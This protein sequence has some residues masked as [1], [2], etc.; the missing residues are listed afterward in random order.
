MLAISKP[1]NGRN[2][3]SSSLG[4]R[5]I[6]FTSILVTVILFCFNGFTTNKIFLY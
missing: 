3:T 6:S 2:K 5:L 4:N 1:E